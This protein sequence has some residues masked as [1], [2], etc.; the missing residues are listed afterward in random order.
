MFF[1]VTIFVRFFIVSVR[2]RLIFDELYF[3]LLSFGLI[4]SYLMG[5]LIQMFFSIHDIIIIFYNGGICYS[6][7]F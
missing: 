4:T 5:T 3:Y 2:S 7:I 6:L 1:V